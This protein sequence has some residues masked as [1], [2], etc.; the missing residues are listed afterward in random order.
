MS[1]SP[2]VTC[3][4]SRGTGENV[5][6]SWPRAILLDFYGTVVE[7]DDP[8]IASVRQ[9]IHASATANVP[10]DPATV[11]KYWSD[12]FAALCAASAGPTFATQR[13]LERRSLQGTLQHFG[14]D[15]DEES[16]SGQLFAYWRQPPIFSDSVAFLDG[17]E[18]PVCIVSNIDRSDLDA[19]INHHGL[20]VDLVVTSE[21]ARAYKPRPEP[22]RL[23]L[24]LLGLSP[25]QVLHIGD[26]LTS[27]VAG[28]TALGI[29]VAWVNRKARTTPPHC[30]ATY[31]T[32]DLQSVAQA[33]ATTGD[34]ASQ[35]DF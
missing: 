34:P 28:A 23:A 21:E 5:A 4:P 18:R 2:N 24:D 20:T 11:G 22:F 1:G 32:P 25:D 15:A 26:S 16:L 3:V 13:E 7:E 29:P 6:V 17:L 19:A 27:D 33:W 8:V 35:A 12:L 31:E 14:S 10:A 30:R 9:A